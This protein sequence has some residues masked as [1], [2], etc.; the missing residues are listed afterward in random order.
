MLQQ[1]FGDYFLIENGRRSLLEELASTVEDQL[2]FRSG[3]Q[4]QQ[5]LGMTSVLTHG[6]LWT[7]N[8]LWRRVP[9]TQDDTFDDIVAIIDWQN[10]HAGNVAEDFVRLLGSSVDPEI[11]RGELNNLI[12]YYHDCLISE[13]RQ[14]N[15]QH[16]P[17][18][19]D[20]IRYAYER[21]FGQGL[22]IMLPSLHGHADE[23]NGL[24]GDEHVQ[25]RQR[26]ILHRCRC[27]IED[28]L[29]YRKKIEQEEAEAVYPANILL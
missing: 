19:T 22:L 20:Q 8:I 3:Q 1:D 26:R 12:E 13:L 21:L 16:I 9:D 7:N 25:E 23:G 11:R 29:M 18:T 4:V 5:E 2:N 17:F 28:F 15:F 24:L 27:L 14:K 10:V 6:D